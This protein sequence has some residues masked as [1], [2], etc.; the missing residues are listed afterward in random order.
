VALVFKS[1]L[2][3]W[4]LKRVLKK[5]VKYKTINDIE[6]VYTLFK[7]ITGSK[8]SNSNHRQDIGKILRRLNVESHFNLGKS[9]KTGGDQEIIELMNSIKKLLHENEKIS[10]FSE[11][12]VQERIVFND[13][14]TLLEHNDPEAVKGKLGELANFLI[15]ANERKLK[16]DRLTKLSFVLAVVSTLITVI[17][18]FLK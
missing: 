2:T 17:S 14:L 13:A 1:D 9:K 11:L 8:T 16:S 18:L 6:D 5:A 4:Q 7:G 10:P 3:A 15:I 12:P